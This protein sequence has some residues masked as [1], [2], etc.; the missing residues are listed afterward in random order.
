MVFDIRRIKVVVLSKK[1]R[2]E[3][4]REEV[5]LKKKKL[6]KRNRFVILVRYTHG[7]CSFMLTNLSTPLP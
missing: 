2:K 1:K 7:I 6:I 4:K 5:H 3:K